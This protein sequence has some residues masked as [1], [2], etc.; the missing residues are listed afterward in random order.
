VVLEGPGDVLI[1]Q[2]LKFEF[3][4]SNN[5]A[6]YE[7]IIAGLNLALDL[8]V[9][10]L[11]CRS[12]SQVV[13]DQLKDE[14]KV[15]E[16]LLHQYY[17]FVQGLIAKFTKVTIQHIRR[18]HNTQADMLSH[19]AKGKKKGLHRLVIYV[20]LSNPT[21]SSE[22]CMATNTEPSLMTP[23]KQFLIDGNCEPHSEKVMKQQTTR[24]LLLI[25]LI[26]ISLILLIFI[27]FILLI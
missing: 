8:E 23:I 4:T 17:H 9:K 12:D 20:T 7:V 11:I 27:L 21:I 15:K 6:E 1:E 10:K 18:E 5:Q 19:L 2:G 3:K 14:F 22:E 16:T 25:L 26:L 24:F 13:V